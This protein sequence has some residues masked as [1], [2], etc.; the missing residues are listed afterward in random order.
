MTARQ[1]FFSLLL[2]ILCL[3]MFA[4]PITAESSDDPVKLTMWITLPDKQAA[5]MTSLDEM[6]AFIELQERMN[7][8]IEF[9]HPASTQA[10]E[11]FNLLVASGEF[12]D[13][14]YFNWNGIDINE[15]IE[16]GFIYEF[17]DVAKEKAPNYFAAAHT[18]EEVLRQAT[19]AGENGERYWGFKFLQL[20]SGLRAGGPIIRE[21][22]L[23][24]LNLKAPVTVDD[25]HNVLCSFR[26]Q[27]P[28]GNGL[29]DEIPLIAQKDNVLEGLPSWASAFGVIQ[30]WCMKDGKVVYG[31]IE[32]GFREYLATMS[33]WYS[34]GLIDPDYA[35]TDGTSF[36]SKATGDLGGAWIGRVSGTLGNYISAR[37]NDG[38]DFSLIGIPWAQTADGH[39]YNIRSNMIQMSTNEATVITATSKN[40]DT[41]LK[42]LDYVYSPE[43]TLLFNFGIEGESYTMVDGIPTYT[44]VIT[45]NPNGLSVSNAIAHY[46][47]A[48][49]SFSMIQSIDYFNQTLIYD[50][51]KTAVRAWGTSE[52][53]LLVPPITLNSDEIKRLNE[54]MADIDT[55]VTEW[56]TK[57]IMGQVS[58][59]E[60]DQ[61]V[62]T[63]K[64]MGIEEA[65]EIQNV[66]YLR[67]IG[68]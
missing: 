42:V 34:E 28:N 25:W 13:M 9:I 24:K 33:K 47:M 6:P 49:S 68:E 19:L 5:S 3:M 55:L 51:Q 11:S 56:A 61:Y 60:F 8:D 58:V 52:T 39:S 35:S 53:S 18:N 44:D 66:A 40:I 64:K 32:E 20:D 4:V 23:E 37:Y 2:S 31:P 63:I 17:T 14:V 38:T 21:D 1:R 30:G 50:Q 45:N 7:V 41:C 46:A 57:T 29:A 67:D 16:D 36:A 15:Y 48:A 10:T 26:D 65:I 22:W 27:D 54:I 59:D 62:Q 43:G 12:P